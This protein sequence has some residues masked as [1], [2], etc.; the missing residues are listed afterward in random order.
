M[1]KRIERLT[2]SLSAFICVHLRLKFFP[3]RLV[4]PLY[5]PPEAPLKYSLPEISW[6]ALRNPF[7]QQ[8]LVYAF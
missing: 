5:R 2:H 8:N 1:G 3:I 6:F 7:F 4:A